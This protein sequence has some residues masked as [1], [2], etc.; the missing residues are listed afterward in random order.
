MANYP[1]ELVLDEDTEKRLLSYLD[2]EL[3]NHFAEHGQF[4]TKLTRW[5]KDYWAEPPSESVTFPF[6]NAATLIIPLTATSVEAIHARNMST[7]FA[8][9]QLTS[10]KITNPELQDLDRPVE[11]MID[12]ELKHGV[13]FR[14][15][16]EPIG[17]E[18][19]KFGTGIG[20]SGYEKVT[21]TAIRA[22]T[23]GTEEAFTV[24]TKNSAVV[25]PVPLAKFMMPYYANDPQESPWVGEEHSES[26]FQIKLKVE[27][28][29]FRPD[30]MEKMQA[31]LASQAPILHGEAQFREFELNQQELQKQQMA[32][33][34]RIEW[35]EVWMSFDINGDGVEEEIVVH[36]HRL[37]RTL[38]SVRYNWYS[39]LH[40][41]YRI[42]QYFPVEHRWAG[43]GICKQSE[44]FQAEITTQH[45]QRL[46]NATLANVRMIKVNKLANVGPNEPIFPGKIWLVD[47]KD[48]VETFQLGEV[49]PSA[50]QNEFSTLQYHQQRTGINDV[51][52]GMPQQGTPGTATDVLARVQEGNKKFDYTY[53]NFKRL[54][55]DVMLDVACNIHQFGGRSR[56]YAESSG[57]ATALQQFFALP[58][59]QL[60]DGFIFEITAAGQQQNKLVDRQNW[61]NIFQMTGSYFSQLLQLAE[62]T[63]DQQ[64]LAVIAK[65]APMAAT[66][67]MKQ[68]F[69]SY[70][71]RD[72][73]KIILSELI[74]NVSGAT[75]IV[76]QAGV[77]GSQIV[78]PQFGGGS[79]TPSNNQAQD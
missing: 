51:L 72:V 41:P 23:D 11:R 28:G 3:I 1:R 31:W 44:A 40:R 7:L 6:K 17:L 49:Y 57:D 50:Y 42:G 60:R 62:A 20:K 68:I 30:V 29:F 55:S 46:D 43:I 36:Y 35:F 26:P 9:D 64:L 77:R 75:P 33:P 22:N 25:D 24:I 54:V 10:V 76:G 70:D 73:N 12:N 16:I 56:M 34:K 59:E 74:N 2:L 5:Q 32:W 53:Q 21:R 63:G 15:A 18:L 67:V 39:D 14:S 78:V 27:S 66:E 65:K 19:V 45:R 69:E 37:S 61:Q 79:P 38:M 58:I 4:I 13:K 8:L 71:I 48:D 47:N 52:L